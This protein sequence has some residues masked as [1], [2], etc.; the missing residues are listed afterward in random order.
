LKELEGYIS[1]AKCYDTSI[2]VRL[3]VEQMEKNIE[4]LKK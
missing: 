1:D 2:M 3:K 4:E